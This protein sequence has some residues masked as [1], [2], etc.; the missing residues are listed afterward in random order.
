MGLF[1][2]VFM[3]QNSSNLQINLQLN[4][5]QTI[6]P[7]SLSDT[8]LTVNPSIATDMNLNQIISDGYRGNG[9]NIAILDSGIS[10]EDNFS[11]IKLIYNALNS[12]S[13][14]DNLGHGTQIASLIA[15][16]NLGSN[17]ISNL[18]YSGIATDANLYIYK[19]IDDSGNG[20]SM[21][22]ITALNQIYE[23]NHDENNTNDI[24]IISLSFGSIDY[25]EEFNQ[26]FIDL[27][28]DGILIIAS[29][30][31]E[32]FY[33]DEFTSIYPIYYSINSPGSSLELITVGAIETSNTIA[34]YSSVGPTSEGVLKPD[35]IAPG[36][37]I[38]V[39]DYT[40]SII[41][42]SGTSFSTPI[43]TAGISCVL[44]KLIDNGFDLPSPNTIKMALTESATQLNNVL[45]HAQGA[46]IPDFEIMY[47][48]LVSYQNN[49]SS[50]KVSIYPSSLIFPN[51]FDYEFELDA[52]E[53][54]YVYPS[55]YFES[56]FK[57]TLIV[58]DNLTSSLSIQIDNN[59]NKFIEVSIS[60]NIQEANQYII[61][62]DFVQPISLLGEYMGKIVF[63][64][65]IDDEFVEYDSIEVYISISWLGTLRAFISTIWGKFLLIGVGVLSVGLII[66]TKRN[67][68]KKNSPSKYYECPDGYECVYDSESKSFIPIKKK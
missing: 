42:N 21:D 65:I 26:I 27:W 28:N 3:K 43:I 68:N 60:D 15:G 66:K 61:A 4:N 39:M 18:T 7:S 2:P 30:G 20:S 36:S 44:S 29:A 63:G 11:N 22:I 49:S 58:R 32:G 38:R 24:H 45:L 9:I 59:I 33:Y 12:S 25:S 40:G 34:T 5:T 13:S 52:E 23:Q 17:T 31:N 48:L 41:L 50:S 8:P 46:G 55:N 51:L 6:Q 56:C 16:L 14:E 47:D 37:D 53:A 67:K 10:N 1:L 64:E 57:T 35:V 54:S 62:I 19:V